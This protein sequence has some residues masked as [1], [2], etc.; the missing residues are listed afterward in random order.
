MI[1]LLALLL[2]ALRLLLLLHPHNIS[3][4]LIFHDSYNG[5]KRAGKWFRKKFRMAISSNCSNDQI[6]FRCPIEGE[7]SFLI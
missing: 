4:S 2:F 3:F 7:K 1:L 5:V 6:E